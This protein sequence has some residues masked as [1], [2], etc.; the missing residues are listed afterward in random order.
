MSD[1]QVVTAKDRDQMMELAAY[2]FN[3]EVTEKRRAVFERLCEESISLGAFQGDVLTSQVMV[4]PFNVHLH[5]SVYQMGGIGYVASYPEYRGGGDVAKLMKL[6]LEKMKEAGMSLSYLAPFSYGFYRKYGFEQVFDRLKLTFE[7]SELPFTKGTEGTLKRLQWGDA[8][9]TLKALYEEKNKT[10]V[11][12]LKRS[13]WWW[14]YL[15][16]KHSQRKIG[17]YYNEEGTATGYVIYEGTGMTF[18]IHELIYLTKTAYDRLWQFISSHSASFN[19]FVYFTGT[20]NNEA[21]LLSNPRIKQEI[22]PFMMARIVD[23]EPFLKNYDFKKGQTG[24]CY[25]KVKDESASWNEG[26]WKLQV[27]E[28]KTKVSF[29]ENPSK[30]ELECVLSADIQTWTQIFMNYQPIHHLAFYE[31]ISGNTTEL[32]QLANLLNT[33]TP[34]LA[35]YF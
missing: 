12:P 16:L 3:Q 35:D 24:T 28:N 11:G 34:V 13:D 19:E 7:V 33:G 29:L 27:S 25:L 32:E 9:E 31:R 21:Y 1:Y 8:L 17:I 6:S 22:V 26:V 18:T 14:D 30:T 4:T 2:A 15:M 5:G 20:D 10:A 23:I